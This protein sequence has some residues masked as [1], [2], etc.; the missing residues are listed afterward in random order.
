ML[1][2]CI[3]LPKTIAPMRP[4]IKLLSVI[5]LMVLTS[6]DCSQTVTGTVIDANT[7]HLISGAQVH[8][9]SKAY[10]QIKTNEE[11]DFEI[12]SI[13]GGLLDCPPMKVVISKEGYEPQTVKIDNAGHET[14]QL[15]PLK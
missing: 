12:N 7:D 9:E 15:K 6:C 1:K 2:I 5:L 10:D 8:K 4:V 13:S 3:S 11:G 14:I